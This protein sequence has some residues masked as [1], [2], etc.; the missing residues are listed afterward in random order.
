M[1]EEEQV[2]AALATVNDPELMLPLVDLGLIY[3]VEIEG[4]DVAIT[5]TLTTPA[6]P[7]NQYIGGQIEEALREQVPGIANIGVNIVWTPPWNPSMMSEDARMELGF[8]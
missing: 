8:F 5:M 2:R 3:N 1:V 7:L 6:C 4:N